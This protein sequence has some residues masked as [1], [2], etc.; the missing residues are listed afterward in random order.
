MDA[1]GTYPAEYYP[2]LL[3]TALAHNADIVIGSHMSGAQSQMPVVRRF[4]NLIFARL[5]SF[6]SAQPIARTRLADYTDVS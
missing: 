6:I 3:T 2:T 5:V 1:D 4:G